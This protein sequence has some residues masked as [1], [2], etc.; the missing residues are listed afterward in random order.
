M[1]KPSAALWRP[2]PKGG[3]AVSLYDADDN[4]RYAN[5]TYQGIFLHGFAGPFTFTEILRH[6]ARNGIGVRI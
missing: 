3:Q 1:M 5:E 2:S 6:G 4:L